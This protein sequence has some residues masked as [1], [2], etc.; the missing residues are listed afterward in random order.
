MT[1]F[2]NSM[3]EEKFN[4]YPDDMRKKLLALRA[5]VYEVANN[6]ESIENIE[7]TLKWNEPSF[8]TQYGSPLRIDWKKSKPYQY[9][10]YF[11]CKTKLVET[12]R[13]LFSDR[14]SF[15]GNREIVFKEHEVVDVEALKY[16]VLLSLTYHK[17]KHLH[18]LDG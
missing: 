17:R 7:E 15:E 4:S 16:C 9:S 8:I 2:A 12:F 1:P 13:E 10:M 14:L 11:N 18:M 5:L 3:V 6:E